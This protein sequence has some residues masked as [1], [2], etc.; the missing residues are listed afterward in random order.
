MELNNG[1]NTDEKYLEHGVAT[2]LLIR[3]RK[4]IRI[5]NL[6]GFTN[7]DIELRSKAEFDLLDSLVESAKTECIEEL[8][9]K[10]YDADKEH[11]YKIADLFSMGVQ[12]KDFR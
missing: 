9:E 1:A 4:A 8:A 3:V 7:N 6:N 11:H 12:I 5:A 10:D 2:A